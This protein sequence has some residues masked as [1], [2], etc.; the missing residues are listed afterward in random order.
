M[1]LE[2]NTGGW[3]AGSDPLAAPP[4]MCSGLQGA[5]AGMQGPQKSARRGVRSRHERTRGFAQSDS[6]R[7]SGKV[8]D[9]GVGFGSR[10]VHRRERRR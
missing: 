7:L 8:G 4:S 10:V 5:W 9:A 1:L 2:D 6:G 3:F